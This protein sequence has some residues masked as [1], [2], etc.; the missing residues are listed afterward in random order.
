MFESLNVTE[1]ALLKELLEEKDAHIRAAATRVLSYWHKRMENPLE[2]LASRIADDH[3]RVRLEA[4]RALARIPSARSAELVLSAL[5]RPLD[6]HLEYALWLSIND[7]AQPWA[8]AVE[9]GAWNPAGRQKQL[10]YG[11]KAIEPA[12]ASQL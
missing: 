3:P 8:A 6:P 12:L 1:P 9:S 11:L 5:E 7:L 4:A 10:E 2:L